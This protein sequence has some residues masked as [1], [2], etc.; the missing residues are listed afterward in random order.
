MNLKLCDASTNA[1]GQFVIIKNKLMSVFL[2]VAFG[3]SGVVTVHFSFRVLLIISYVKRRY[4]KWKNY[5]YYNY[6]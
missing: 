6:Y 5:Y 1:S 2:A 4:I 3:G